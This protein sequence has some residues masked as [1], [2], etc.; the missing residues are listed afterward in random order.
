MDSEMI[1]TTNTQAGTTKPITPGAESRKKKNLAS[2][3]STL[4]RC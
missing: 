3:T 2:C 4:C 1:M